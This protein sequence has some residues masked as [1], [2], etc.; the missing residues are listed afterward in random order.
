MEWGWDLAKAA[1]NLAK[2]Q[3]SFEL[4]ARA[5]SDPLLIVAADPHADNDRWRAIGSPSADGRPVLVV[6]Y[7]EPDLSVPDSFGRIIS[8]RV[9]TSQERCVYEEGDD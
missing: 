8:A 3:V 1:A 4:A 7:T 6:V 2:H 5:L 9:A